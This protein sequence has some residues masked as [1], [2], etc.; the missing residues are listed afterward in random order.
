MR[1]D[2]IM[3]ESTLTKRLALLSPAKRS[4]LEMKLKQGGIDA[5]LDLI[6]RRRS[7]RDPAPLS[8]A[9]QR[10]WFLRQL[11][12]D[13]SA[14]N[15][16]TPIR[17]CGPLDI[18]AL[19][20][21]LDAIVE[22]HETLRTNFVMSDD[23]PT[24][25]INN[26]RSVNVPLV[27]LSE[28]PE[29]AR[30]SELQR[31]IEG[32]TRRPF[33]LSRDLML[34]ACLLKLSTVEHVLILVTHHIASDGW[35]SGILWQ[36]LAALYGAYLR[37]EANPLP[38]LPIQYADYAEWQRQWLQGEVLQ[39][40]LSYWKE[41][42]SGVPILDLPTDRPRPAVQTYRGARQSFVFPKT[43]CDQLR[44]L[45]RK[46]GVTLFMTL[47]AAFQTLLQRYSGQD[48]I[49]VG[50]PIAGRTRSETEGLIGFF[51]NTLVLRADLSGNPSFREVLHRVRQMA[52]GAYEYQDIPFEK[53]V[54]ELHPDRDLSRSPLFQ[55]LFAFQNVPRQTRELAGLTVT[56]LENQ[57]ETAKFDASLYTW[58]EK[59]GLRARLEYNTDLYDDA[60]ISRMLGHF[61]T[62]LEGIVSNPEQ[63][64]CDLAILSEA[65]RH[66]VVVEWNDR[67]RD[68]P[69]ENCIHELFEAQVEKTPDSVAAVFEEKQL[70]YREL[71]TKAN[72]LAH[73]LQ[74]LGV[75][76]GALVG[77]CV[78]RSLE[79]II[80]LLSILKAGGAYVPL[81]PAYPKERL[82]F[83]LQDAQVAVLITQQQLRSELPSEHGAR[84]LCIDTEW[85]QVAEQADTNP[86][87][88]AKPEDL[89]YVIYTSGST[90][91]PKGVQ[92]AHGAVVNF[93]SSM[94]AQPGLTAADTLLAVTTLSFDIAGLELYLP[95]SVG[96]RV[97]I[98]SRETAIDGVV[99]AENL[100]KSGATIMQATPTTWRMLLETGWQGSDH[101]K[102]LCGGEALSPEL[103]TE[104]LP[105]CS[106]L[107]N[108]YGPTETTIW[109]S[110][111]KVETP[112][113]QIP[114]GRPIGNTQLYILDRNQQP[115]PI[116]VPGELYIGGD[117]LALGYLNRDEL[118]DERFV[119]D[120]F[121]PQAGKRLYKTG[122]RARWRPDG[123]IEI[124]GRLDHQVKIRGFR[125][126]LGEIEAA[127][128]QHSAVR[129]TVVVV[130]E[131]DSGDKQLVGYVV[132]ERGSGPAADELR[133]VLRQK[134]P[135]Y[136]IPGAIVIVDAF[137]L[138]PNGKLDRNALPRPDREGSA[139]ETYE[140]P[141]TPAEETMAKIWADV[142]KVERV[143]VHDNFFDL[144]GHS[145]LATKV[146]SRVRATFHIDLPLRSLFQAPTVA[147]LVA[148]IT[149]DQAKS[150]DDEAL[151]RML[152]ELESLPAKQARVDLV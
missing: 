95:L 113:G 61:E 94:Q 39:R 10:L 18:A 147:G 34:R 14:Y 17:L 82:A 149:E 6:I 66:Q 25:V 131:N 89:A 49:A 129:D 56:P 30:E 144:G 76:P 85:A 46:E 35:S 42:L 69:R 81:D 125:I 24:Q 138:T 54:E 68:Y 29:T 47:L 36:E 127:I 122:D 74:E 134:L 83:M 146:I 110:I 60:T 31:G 91:K 88:T 126:E 40:Q 51:V 52:L 57:N 62:L 23:V 63:R 84:L 55:V 41:Q 90:G 21:A 139:S 105:R 115:L 28:L 96:A 92:I 64:I 152:T 48:D 151:D 79:M 97:V 130:Q 136:M 118:T 12:P 112:N 140:P 104:L 33:D 117:G 103:A 116:D 114:I 99:L 3:D 77:I 135:D 141:R 111:Y 73:Y 124:L 93:L 9:Q 75:G 43:L 7:M 8:F 102:I 15:Q 148:I 19:T 106:S 59:E 67:R 121:S 150:L 44:G 50:S 70:T 143:G 27:N 37:G 22:R 119:V 133:N 78:E 137:P 58:E 1:K 20:K 38:E 16:S 132:E 123:N 108:M 72:Q 101:L 100:V 107:W 26:P 65:E 120:P 87:H 80:G 53:L 2:Y 109:S 128:R 5:P 98:V 32:I 145:L 13:S 11:E 45:S 4:L 142:L 86:D 71:N